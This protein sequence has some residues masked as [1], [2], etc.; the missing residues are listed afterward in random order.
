[1]QTSGVLPPRASLI[2][3][4][5]R[6]V[7]SGAKSVT[8]L[9]PVSLLKSGKSGVIAF[10]QGWIAPVSVIVCPANC[11]QLIAALAYAASSPARVVRGNV[12]PAGKTAP[13]APNP[14][15]KLRRLMGARSLDEFPSMMVLP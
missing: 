11:F 3:I 7:V 2:G 15:T 13:A 4:A 10:D 8:T 9:M 1:M 5:L 6:Y 12:V 14:L